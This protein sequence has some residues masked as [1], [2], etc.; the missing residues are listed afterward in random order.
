MKKLLILGLFWTLKLSAQ[1]VQ[2]KSGNS[3]IDI[4]VDADQT[5]TFYY[6]LQKNTLSSVTPQLIKDA[7]LNGAG[8]RKGSFVVG[9]GQ[10]GQT[11]S[12][13][14]TQLPQNTSYYLYVAFEPTAAAL[15]YGKEFAVK[16]SERFQKNSYTSQV[17]TWTNK[18]VEYLAYKNEAY[19]KD[20]TGQKR[21]VLFFF[22]GDGEK[23]RENNTIDILKTSASL[24]RIV[25]EGKDV[26][27]LVI[28]PQLPVSIP[29]VTPGFMNELVE[30]VKAKYNIDTNRIYISGYS[31]GGGGMYY[32]AATQPKKI[33]ATVPVSAVN[34]FWGAPGLS[35]CA[36][37]DIPLWGF[38]ADNDGTVNLNNLNEPIKQINACIP[39]P[40]VA[41]IKTVYNNVPDPHGYVGYTAF[42]LDALYE[43]ILAKTKLSPATSAPV[44][45]TNISPTVQTGGSI[46]LSV[47]ATSV[48]GGNISYEWVKKSGPDVT[49]LGIN[50]PTLQLSNVASGSYLFR[51]FAKDAL[52]STSYKDVTLVAS[53]ISTG[54][55]L[56]YA[57]AG[58]DR[59]ITLPQDTLTLRGTGS[60][61][62]G[63]I[64]SYAWSKSAGPNVNFLNGTNSQALRLGGL[65][66]GT[67]VFNL[68]VTDNKGGVSPSDQVQVVV[69]DANIA[70]TVSAGADQ[71]IV[72]SSNPIQLKGVA[73]DSDGSVI[74]YDWKQVSGPV[75]SKLSNASTADLT[76]AE[77]TVGTFVYQLEVTDNG[78][79]K[80]TDQ[81]SIKVNQAVV[82][83][84]LE[85]ISP[86]AAQ[87]Y[88]EGSSVTVK[89]DIGAASVQY[90]T[91]EVA[92]DKKK[93][94]QAPFE[95]TWTG[96]PTGS[97]KALVVAVDQ[98]GASVNA[99]QDFSITPA[100]TLP[101][102]YQVTFPQVNGYNKWNDKANNV[103]FLGTI[104]VQ[105]ETSNL[106][107][108]AFVDFVLKGQK[109]TDTWP[110]AISSAP[111]T[112]AFHSTYYN[113][114]EGNYD[115]AITV[116]DKKGVK[117]ETHAIFNV[118]NKEIFSSFAF[119][120]ATE[121]Y[122]IYD[123]NGNLVAQGVGN[124]LE[125]TTLSAGTYILKTQ[126]G[127]K[128]FS[129]AK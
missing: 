28:A 76:I 93:L 73:N 128:L 21:P 106:E 25:N 127:S 13:V 19:S 31:G 20:L 112:Y 114:P 59:T 24:V 125:N 65:A 98:T 36:I 82:P 84:T 117:T 78:G 29:W 39:A 92:G 42:R 33:A 17:P 123:L 66:K 55:L 14:I 95:Y 89:A 47:S 107:N 122:S 23:R 56:P 70:P 11:L 49:A 54:N 80:S 26:D 105:I 34:G 8:D 18:P 43:W 91:I 109:N 44:I 74:S 16:I 22:H 1:T 51:V 103:F 9:A 115:V 46:N 102:G 67:Y 61:N 116:T 81:V 68:S 101:T 7:S 12:R 62:D 32:L 77:L 113:L 3:S 45:S 4:V 71:T 30:Q 64:V 72:F 50:S 79:L 40:L 100:V 96:L 37:K 111:T 10:V 52:G 99:G 129:L 88:T 87:V 63:S 15:I 119:A 2:V 121:P 6:S 108:V 5:G 120:S 118:S 35:Y 110:D 75:A 97:Y 58:S 85:V 57:N 48:N 27:M 104:R 69:K 124:A 41:P 126:S 83:L 94:T 90:V 60:D 86:K 53:G 38:H